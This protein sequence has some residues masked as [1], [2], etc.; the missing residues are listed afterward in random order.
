[1]RLRNDALAALGPLVGIHVLG[2]PVLRL[3][4]GRRWTCKKCGAPMR[5]WFLRPTFKSFVCP[6]CDFVTI[7]RDETEGRAVAGRCGQG[8]AASSG[9]ADGPVHGEE[10]GHHS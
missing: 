4:E 2:V 9:A 7:V 1:M 8:L 10:H 6:S 3:R 5:L